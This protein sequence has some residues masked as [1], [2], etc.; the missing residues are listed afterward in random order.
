MIKLISPL[1]LF[2]PSLAQA[3]TYAP[4]IKVSSSTS[5]A[6]TVSSVYNLAL[7]LGAM[8]AFGIIV[9]AAL[10]YTA[11][12]NPSVQQ[13]AKSR[14]YQALLGLLLL[15][16]AT[17]VLQFINPT[18][19]TLRNPEVE[20]L[21]NVGVATSTGEPGGLEPPPSGTTGP[22]CTPMDTGP[23][24]ASQI[25]EALRGTSMEGCFGEKLYKASGVARVESGGNPSVDS[26]GDRC[27]GESVSIG[28]FQINLT[29]N[30]LYDGNK[31]VML[32][33][34]K[35]FNGRLNN[36]SSVCTV[37]DRDLYERCKTAAKD[38]KVNTWS[39]CYIFKYGSAKV[40]NSF[41]RWGE[42]TKKKCG[43]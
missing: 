21:P 12:D 28:L 38:P 16:G 25:E 33:C 22:D 42:E 17:I 11:T 15:L 9:Y 23:G 43:I 36:P 1:L 32:E 40:K 5:P 29:W 31:K 4:I 6:S 19:S 20:P 35:A 8:A 27:S 14:I 30:N 41:E 2:F 10:R 37:A 3:V 7:G 26:V 18:L 34:N 24:K 39:A 13:Y